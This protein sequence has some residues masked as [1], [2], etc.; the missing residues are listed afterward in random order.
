MK[1]DPQE[2]IARA[3]EA[4]QRAVAPY[5][6]FSVGCAV[7]TGDGD[8]VLGCNIELSS[9]GLTMC[10]ERVAVFKAL[11]D[12]QHLITAVAIVADT[13]SVCYPCGACRQVLYEFAPS[14]TVICANLSGQFEIYQTSDLIPHAFGS[15]DLG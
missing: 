14:A 7:E 15:S 10:A 4:R 5:S 6:R 12:G 8:I 13:R 11:S 2:L 3:L 9:Y 1:S